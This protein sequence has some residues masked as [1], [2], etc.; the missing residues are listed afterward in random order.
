MARRCQCAFI[1]ESQVGQGEG[2]GLIIELLTVCE[3]NGPQMNSTDFLNPTWDQVE[4]AIRALD[5]RVRNDLYLQP[6]ASSPETYLAVGG[7]KGRYVVTG[8]VNNKRFPTAVTAVEDNGVRELL[9]VGGQTGDY[10]RSW[11]LDLGSA[12]RAARS[13]C[14]TGE[15]AG[16]GVTWLEA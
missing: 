15:F 2:V 7:G 11:I 16:G 13:F 5:E 12:L 10:P 4:D 8:S 1:R 6:T 3:W 14:D 9:V